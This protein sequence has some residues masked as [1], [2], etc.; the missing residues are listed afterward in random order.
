MFR[1]L[2]CLTWLFHS[3]LRDRLLKKMLICFPSGWNNKD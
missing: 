2:Q 1:S 3:K